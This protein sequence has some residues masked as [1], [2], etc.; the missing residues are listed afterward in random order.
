MIKNE[1]CDCSF[2]KA[3]FILGSV[4]YLVSQ[5][6]IS[7][8]PVQYRV[9]RSWVANRQSTRTKKKKPLASSARLH[10][11]MFAALVQN[12]SVD[13]GEHLDAFL[14]HLSC[15][16]CFGLNVTADCYTQR[17]TFLF[18]HGGSVPGYSRFHLPPPFQAGPGTDGE[19]H[20]SAA[21]LC[22][23]YS[24]D[25]TLGCVPRP[26]LGKCPGWDFFGNESAPAYYHHLVLWTIG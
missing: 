20:P 2:T 24:N 13:N 25:W 16:T 17:P 18:G 7:N 3:V 15:T 10:V 14:L 12:T 8:S 19:V 23:Q 11:F 26:P 4:S 22:S 21:C 6:F 5:L 9:L 1:K